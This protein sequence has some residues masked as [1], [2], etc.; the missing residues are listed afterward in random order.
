MLIRL[1]VREGAAEKSSEADGMR[2]NHFKR[3]LLSICPRAILARRTDTTST[4]MQ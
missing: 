1:G 2:Q 3:S 4:S